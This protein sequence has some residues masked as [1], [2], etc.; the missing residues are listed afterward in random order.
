M[1]FSSYSTAK[2]AVALLIAVTGLILTVFSCKQQEEHAN[3]A[4]MKFSLRDKSYPNAEGIIKYCAFDAEF[5]VFKDL[6]NSLCSPTQ[7]DGYEWAGIVFY[8]NSTPNLLLPSSD[9]PEGEDI[10]GVSIFMIDPTG[11]IHHSFYG[12]KAGIFQN[13]PE[14][15]LKTNMIGTAKMNFVKSVLSKEVV[16]HNYFIA[17]NKTKNFKLGKTDDEFA[18]KIK[19][20][21]R[22]VD[23]LP[24]NDSACPSPCYDQKGCDCDVYA[25][26]EERY[27]DPCIDPGDCILTNTSTNPLVKKTYSSQFLAAYLD[28]EKYRKFR[29][30]FLST[31]PTGRKFIRYYDALSDYLFHHSNYNAE[32]VIETVKYL[33]NISKVVDILATE[34]SKEVVITEKD[35]LAY[36][37]ILAKYKTI[38]QSKDY[39]FAISDIEKEI[40]NFTGKNRAELIAYLNSN[41]Y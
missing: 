23:S 7:I 16:T 37:A 33:P 22:V 11:I 5:K 35:R 18:L 15:N 26:T 29:E 17:L 8:H 39:Q 4:E 21:N 31:K 14:L 12:K 3:S 25:G 1:K 10:N 27:C 2:M 6:A 41:N 28:L 30:D 38:S 36:M 34:G 32:M 40:N 19:V 24:A 20:D 13:L 9:M